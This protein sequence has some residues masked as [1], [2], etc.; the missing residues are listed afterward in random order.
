MFFVRLA[1]WALGALGSAVS[2]QEVVLKTGM[3]FQVACM[4]N[5]KVMTNGDSGENNARITLTDA[6]ASSAG[7]EWMLMVQ[8]ETEMTCM[9][10]NPT[11]QKAIDMAPTV[12]ALLQWTIASTNANQQFRL[13]KVNGLEN[14]YKISNAADNT[15]V[16]TAQANGALAMQTDSDGDECRFRLI[17]MRQNALTLPWDKQYYHLT[18]QATGL[19]LDVAGGVENKDPVTA[20]TVGEDESGQTWQ[21]L[22]GST[23]GTFV[24]KNVKSRKALDMALDGQQVPLQW[25]VTTTNKNQQVTFVPLSGQNGVYQ[26]KGVRSSIVRYL[27]VGDAG[28]VELTDDATD[29]R[30]Y[31][32][33]EGTDKPL[34]D[35]T[36]WEDET[37]FEENKEPGHAVYV[38]Y[39]STEQMQAD[40]CYKQRWLQPER[41]EYRTLNGVW[42]FRFVSEPSLRPGEEEF[43]GDEADVSE[44]DTISV[45]SCWEMKGYDTPMYVNAE[46][47]FADNPPYIEILNA[48]RGQFGAN[49][50]GSYRRDFELP[51]EW[52]G[53]RVFLHFDGIYSAA[54]VWVN[55]EYVGYTQGANND[56]EFDVTE[57]LRP[58]TNNVS[59]Q[60]LRWSDGA[61]L[62]GQDMF[63]MSGIFRDVYL[64]ATPQTFVRDHYITGTLDA[65]DNYTS[66]SLH[67]Q[68]E[69]SNRGKEAVSKQVEVE[70]LAPEG[71]VLAVQRREMTFAAGDSTL[72]AT[73]AI[74]GLTDLRLWSAET[75]TLY[76]VVVRQRTVDGQEESVFSTPYGFRHVEIRDAR[77]Y[78][79]GKA[80][81]FKGVNTQDTHPVYGRSIDVNTMLTDVRMMKQANVNTVRTSHYPRQSKMNAMFDYY[82]LYVMDEADVECHKNWTDNGGMS[83]SA[84]WRA[85]YVDRTVRM[86]LRDRN[87]PS[88]IFW[89][90]GNESGNGSNF[91]ATYAATR[92]LD[93]RIIHYEGATRIPAGGDNTELC[94]VM[95]PT[96]TT[97][98][99]RANVYADGKPFFICEYAHAMG[100]SVG[101]L[102]EYWDIIEGSAYGI[103]GCI[104]DWVDQSIYS[105]QALLTGETEKNGFPV[106]T[107]GYD[108]PGPHQGNFVNNGLITADRAWTAKLT[109][110]KHVY[111]YVKFGSWDAEASRLTLTNAYDFIS[112]DNFVLD[113][114]VLRD[115]YVAESGRVELPALA[116]GQTGTVSLP[117]HTVAGD[118]AEYLLNVRVCRKQASAWADADYVVADWQYVLQERAVTLPEHTLPAEGTLAIRNGLVRTTVQNEHVSL[119]FNKTTGALEGWTQMGNSVLAANPVY[120]NFLWIENDTHGDTDGG[121]G[122]TTYTMTLSPDKTKC[123]VQVDV[124]GT[125]CPY[126]LLY[127]IYTDGTV[128]LKT[129][130]RPQADDIRRIGL[131]TQF[132]A[133]YEEVE[134]YARGPWENYTDR[135]TGSFL[136][137]YHTTVTDMF[138]MYSH[139]Q[140]MANREAL[141]QLVL[142][143][144]TTGDS[145]LVSTEG[146][147]AFSLLHYDDEKFGQTRLHPWELTKEKTTYA[148][149]DYVQRGLGNSSCGPAV[150]DKYKC[151]SE[152]EYTYTL[153]FEVR[154]KFVDGL[155]STACD[156]ASVRVVYDG[157]T[158]TVTC[159]GSLS[160]PAEVE[161][162]NLGGVCLGKATKPSG[163]AEVRLPLAGCPRGAYLLKVTT[164]QGV[165]SH[166][167][168]KW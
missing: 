27:T 115:G 153:R 38:P 114:E 40:D 129:T 84:T 90:L 96:L 89:S 87:H 93:S 6:E 98:D 50:V 59:V 32:T 166:K 79:N 146:Q 11:Y 58:G 124:D 143:N 102:Q 91:A 10:V 37:F 70:L 66:G 61:Y 15:Q 67:V 99:Y 138:E 140:S 137:R 106:Y 110:V 120:S 56:A 2:A 108:Y 54:F 127:T 97:V 19:R 109:E 65:A 48:Y 26:L 74:E 62:E 57:R 21:L 85:Q 14:V 158:Q 35:V 86:V 34:T 105:P 159:A 12:G 39:S 111:Q 116:P 81:Y 63:H 36:P 17:P 155:A 165:R 117:M 60:V 52:D 144:A 42:K 18:H 123:E 44:W 73:L 142:L 53:K 136:G 46:Y 152:G 164:P 25:T 128:D 76:T 131:R 125:L 72:T 43:Y 151:P 107:T 147:V 82:G 23:A 77:V 100:N 68:V 88:V 134:Y 92:A 31:F 154:K 55:G 41:A 161:L 103:G 16:V 150:L 168:L 148:R 95:Y 135:C 118:E 24:L 45:P 8:D 126:T 162:F 94:S 5:D 4:A 83:Q 122:S 51:A 101:N 47:P 113:Y 64:F 119:Q 69:M 121:V 30:T 133:D 9:W 71:D 149:F 49:P 112:L 75:P 157:D 33:L 160:E 167:F 29:E 156:R 3:T 1:V 13:V 78:V 132:P 139:P 130:F 145:V 20:S 80:V 7:Q 22:A 141:R 163:T 104:W 28:T